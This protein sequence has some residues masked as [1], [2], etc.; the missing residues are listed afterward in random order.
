MWFTGL[1]P[2]SC[3]RLEREGALNLLLEKLIGTVPHDEY[4]TLP[5]SA[6]AVCNT[7]HLGTNAHTLMHTLERSCVID[8]YL[9]WELFFPQNTA[10]SAGSIDMRSYEKR[11]SVPYGSY[12]FTTD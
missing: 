4:S 7:A 11:G 9:G 1:S 6:S 3:H 8:T 12:L 10:C 2:I 5:A